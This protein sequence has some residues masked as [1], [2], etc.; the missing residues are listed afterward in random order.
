MVSFKLPP[1]LALAVASILAMSTTIE[2]GSSMKSLPMILVG[3]TMISQQVTLAE[4]H[5]S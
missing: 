5:F 1:T 3:A 4:A 2:A